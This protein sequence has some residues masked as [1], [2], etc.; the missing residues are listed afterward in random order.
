METET[1]I[2][3]T[4]NAVKDDFYNIHFIGFQPQD[5][6]G[7][8]HLDPNDLFHIMGDDVTGSDVMRNIISKLPVFDSSCNYTIQCTS[9]G[10]GLVIFDTK[11]DRQIYEV[12]SNKA[13]EWGITY[14]PENIVARPKRWSAPEVKWEDMFE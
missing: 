8:E 6:W 12:I 10:I 9:D 7:V 11:N 5:M 3:P 2:L 4:R 14:I 13:E 1:I